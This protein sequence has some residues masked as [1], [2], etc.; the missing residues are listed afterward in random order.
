[1]QHRQSCSS[2]G[3]SQPLSELL[4][5][6]VHTLAPKHLSHI[7]EYREATSTGLSRVVKEPISQNLANLLGGDVEKVQV[8]WW[9][10]RILVCIY[11]KFPSQT[12]IRISIKAEKR[13]DAKCQ[14]LIHF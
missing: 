8:R 2:H 7:G 9:F 11:V 12:V 4:L 14:I 10:N 1:M 13:H 6:A 5:T 3:S